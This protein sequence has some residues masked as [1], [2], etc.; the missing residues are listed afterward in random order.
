MQLDS[1]ISLKQLCPWDMD[2]TGDW[3]IKK[4]ELQSFEPREP[5]AL[6]KGFL[7]SFFFK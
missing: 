5:V 7:F 1:L 4:C 6:Q 3:V 2:K